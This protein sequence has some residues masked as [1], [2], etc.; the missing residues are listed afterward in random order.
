MADFQLVIDNIWT[1]VKP[2]IVV[3]PEILSKIESEMS[4]VIEEYSRFRKITVELDMPLFERQQMRYP[5]GLYSILNK[6]L[7]EC[8]YTHDVIDAR[9][10]PKFGTQLQMHSKKLRD[11]QEEVV[12]KAIE[13][14]RGVIKIAT[15]G[16]KTVI[17]AAIVARLNLKT[18]FIVYSIDLLQQ[19]ADEFEKMFQIKVGRIGGGIC[20]IKRINICIKK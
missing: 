20:D 2:N 6:I 1:Y 17:A 12:T 5:T 4:Y 15:G 18:L 9:C 16:G 3:K 19:T 10:V 14:E 13:S 7:T 11:Y 8:G